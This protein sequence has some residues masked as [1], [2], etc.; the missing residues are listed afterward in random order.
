MYVYK[1]V[2]VYL[3]KRYLVYLYE[4]FL[5]I[6]AN[7]NPFCSRTSHVTRQAKT[8]P[9]QPTR[10][11]VIHTIFQWA[12]S[13]LVYMMQY[14][15]RPS[16]ICCNTPHHRPKVLRLQRGD[17]LSAKNPKSPQV[18]NVRPPQMGRR[19]CLRDVAACQSRLVLVTKF[20]H[21]DCYS[22]CKIVQK[23]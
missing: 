10:H 9:A 20:W 22:A 8:P 21:T 16:N 6:C 1:N 14:T 7:A 5:Y 23:V 4:R 15:T 2:L 3:C 19:G 11:D 13:L 12:L 18:P 17:R